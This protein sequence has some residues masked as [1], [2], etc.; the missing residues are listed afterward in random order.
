MRRLASW[1]LVGSLA[2][3]ILAWGLAGPAT[4]GEKIVLN[5][6]TAG[7]TNMHEL[8]KDIFGPAFT[9]KFPNVE[10]NA[11][12]SGPG[13]PGS[14]VIFQKLKSEKDA[15]VAKYDIDVA[16]VHQSIMPDMIKNDLLAKY[17]PEISTYKMMT[18]ANGKN[19]LGFNVEG[20]V[21]PMFQS[22]VVLAYNPEMVKTPPNTFEELVAWIKAN[23]KKFGYNGV[24]GGMSGTGFVTGWN[25]WKSGKY[26]QYAK[27]TY[28]KAA[29]AS[30][31]AAIK[32][33][34]GLPVTMTTGN[35]DTLDKLNRG[36]IAMGPV[37]VDMLINMKNEGRMDPKIKMKL[38]SPG[39]PGQP[40]Y[41]VVTKKSANY[42]MAKKFV[43]FI[44]SP[45]EQA[46]VIVERQGWLPGIDAKYVMPE[47]GAKAKDMIFGDLPS[48]TL[49]K[50]GLVFPQQEYF[51]DLLT[52]Y[53]EN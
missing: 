42:E 14:R 21:M 36:E 22:Q 41:L 47:V 51:K 31:P 13:D 45:E 26:D 9:K 29:E 5:V 32:E 24:K 3:A 50:Y 38:I 43:E 17:G 27:G 33:L 10:I 1:M 2:V 19:A 28:D 4:A 46:R 20:Y 49:E 35:N 23:P 30:W 44:T 40:M 18:A 39:L 48:E 25:Y 11:V 6:V 37:W 7:D 8:Q 15:N 16:I 12:G 53:E 52:A 34:K